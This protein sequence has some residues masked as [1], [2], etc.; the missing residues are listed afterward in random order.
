MNTTY[1]RPFV[2]EINSSNHNIGKIIHSRQSIETIL[3]FKGYGSTLVEVNPQF[4]I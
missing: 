2:G 1:D 4:L 3:P